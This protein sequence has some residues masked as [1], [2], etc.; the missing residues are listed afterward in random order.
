MTKQ[1]IIIANYGD[2]DATTDLV[3]ALADM[4]FSIKC[5]MCETASTVQAERELVDDSAMGTI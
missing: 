3:M 4:G 2:Q 5:A 1:T